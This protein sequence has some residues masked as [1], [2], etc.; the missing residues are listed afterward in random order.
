[1]KRLSFFLTSV[2]GT[3][4]KPVEMEALT[5]DRICMPLDPVELNLEKYPH[6]RNLMLADLYSRGSVDIDVLIGADFY[7]SF[8][9]GN[10]VKGETLNSP[11]AVEST[12]GWI[13]SGPIEGQLS[14]SS[15]SMLST[16]RIDSVTASLKQFWE[17]ESIEIVHKNDA[18][19]SVEEE[20]AVRQFN[21]GLKFYGERYVVPLLWKRDTPG[22]NSNYNQAVKRLKSVERQ[23]RR[24]PEK[25]EAY[26]SV[27][28]QYVEKGYAEE[29]KETDDQSK[30]VR[31][32]PHHAVFRE[33][34]RTTKCRVVFDASAR[35]DQDA[36]LN[37]CILSGPAFQPNLV[38]VLLPFRKPKIAL[39]ADLEKMFL[40]IKVD[41]KDQD[42][43]RYVWRDL[44]SDD[45]PGIYR[46][47]RLAFGVNCS[48]F[49][50]IAT[51]Q[52]HAKECK[53]EFPAASMEV[54]SNMYVDDCLTGDDSVEASVELQK[55]LAKMTERGGFNLTKWA[56]NSEEVLSH[57]AIQDQAQSNTID[58]GESE[59][60][61]YKA[62]GICWNTITDSFLFNIPQS[63]LKIND[64]E[65]KRSLLSIASRIFDPKGLLTPFTVK[66]KIQFQDLWQR[67][68]DWEDQLDEEIAA[69]WRSWKSELPC[70]SRITT[71]RHFMANGRSII[72]LHGF[73][74]ASPKAYGAAV[75]IGSMDAA[76]KVSTHLVMSK[77][78]VAPTKTVSLPRLELLAAVMNSR[79]LK[80]VAASLCLKLN[81]VM[82]GLT[83]W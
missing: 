82:A 77:S 43:L 26:K 63:V 70:I 11:T 36:S 33:D 66:A 74:D 57:I 37:D 72:E 48:P 29:V 2:Q 64:P 27:I 73:G 78:R 6:L 62:L 15:T 68:L 80:F 39:M 42:V 67:G 30:K 45:A 75:Y 46:L 83:A 20:D 12:F 58:F 5:I 34:K 51:I 13:V 71:P 25:A 8:V 28:N 32:L 7:F 60:L 3:D 52:H 69:Q 41:E 56:S 16:V 1:M 21:G 10:C 47:Q 35:E 59:P 19:M 61:N 18:F 81:R 4:M 40:Q 49:L 54:L 9:T 79:L 38:S 55:S 14:K 50:A 76:G 53:E 23:L 17:L 24:N 44:K 22:L 31:Y 65:T